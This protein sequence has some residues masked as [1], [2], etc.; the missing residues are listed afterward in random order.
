MDLQANL[1]T[2]GLSLNQSRVYLT[3]LQLGHNTVQQI[4]RWA[5]LKRPT[6]YLVLDD[7]EKMG[8]VNKSTQNNRTVFT[9][10]PPQQL[11]RNIQAKQQL[12]QAILPSLEA[13]YNVDPEKPTIKIAERVDGVRTVYNAIF[14]YLSHHPG[15]ELLIF[16]SLK[17][18]VANF[19]IEV[20]DYFYNMMA[21]SRNAIREIGNDDPETRR[22]YRA[23]RRLNPNHDIRLIHND[24]A[25]LQ[26]DNMMYGDT[27]II[28]SVLTSAN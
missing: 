12:A 2:M 14:S 19:E 8:L 20:I 9:A 28:F 23:S 4:A 24:G 1:T 26:T 11:I 16:G 6:V 17:D 25:F 22:Y 15:E 13:I 27:L 5:N 7:L 10:E 18:A 3:C 21:R